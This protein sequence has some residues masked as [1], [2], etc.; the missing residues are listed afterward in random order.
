MHGGIVG[1][2]VQTR[3]IVD[4]RVGLASDVNRLR[5]LKL[6]FLVEKLFL[7]ETTINIKYIYKMKL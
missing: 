3:S 6:V 2:W 7:K 5:R 1:R 4:K